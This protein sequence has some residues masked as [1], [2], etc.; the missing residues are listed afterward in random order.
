M[1]EEATAVQS[2]AEAATEG[3]GGAEAAEA[4]EAEA[5]T[6][7]DEEATDSA[8]EEDEEG[9]E[10]TDEAEEAEEAAKDEAEKAEEE[11][12][13]AEKGFLRF[14]RF[15]AACARKRSNLE[16]I[17]VPRLLFPFPSASASASLPPWPLSSMSSHWTSLSGTIGTIGSAPLPSSSSSMALLLSVDLLSVAL[18]SLAP[19]YTRSCSL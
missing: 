11:K 13:E 10:G 3:A 12:A 16:S 15:F 9:E 14:F 2:S 1:D 6:E 19:L 4:A 5:A 17:V 8:T 18:S 7:E